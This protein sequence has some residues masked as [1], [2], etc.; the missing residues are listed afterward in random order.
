MAQIVRNV[1][2][3]QVDEQCPACGQGFMRPNGISQM[4]KPPQYQHSCTSCNH[5]QYYSVRYPHIVS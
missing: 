3:N 5:T 4:S 2:V 1:Q